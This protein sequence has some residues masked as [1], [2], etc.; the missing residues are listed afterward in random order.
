MLYPDGSVLSYQNMVP[1]NC[2]SKFC[3]LR[4][5]SY[6]HCMINGSVSHQIWLNFNKVAPKKSI[7]S[8]RAL[9]R[10]LDWVGESLEGRLYACFPLVDSWRPQDSFPHRVDDFMLFCLEEM[11]PKWKSEHFCCSKPQG[12]QNNTFSGYKMDPQ[13][14]EW[15]F[16]KTSLALKDYFSACLLFLGEWVILKRNLAAGS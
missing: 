1:D 6:P 5:V 13:F 11:C 8:K 9:Y 14:S 15:Q 4:P 12:F 7:T 3:T 16:R 10:V 2:L